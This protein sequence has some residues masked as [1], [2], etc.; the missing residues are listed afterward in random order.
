MGRYARQE[1]RAL[2][3][4]LQLQSVQRVVIYCCD[5][6]RI[7]SSDKLSFYKLIKHAHVPKNTV[8][9]VYNTNRPK[10]TLTHT[11]GTAAPVHN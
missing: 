9:S 2:M 3:L 10:Y 4:D 11:D 7:E 5:R 1:V 6:D 8:Y